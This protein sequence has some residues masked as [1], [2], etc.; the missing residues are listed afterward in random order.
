MQNY[1]LEVDWP[2]YFN[3]SLKRS[4]NY[5]LKEGT[6]P[7]VFLVQLRMIPQLD[8]PTSLVFHQLTLTNS[9]FSQWTNLVWVTNLNFKKLKIYIIIKT[10]LKITQFYSFFL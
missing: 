4:T 9:A 1:Q 8:A 6:S 5:E 7:I 3:E 10:N 2:D